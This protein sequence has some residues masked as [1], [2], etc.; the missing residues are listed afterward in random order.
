MAAAQPGDGIETSEHIPVFIDVAGPRGVEGYRPV[1]TTRLA[2]NVANGNFRYEDGAWH[3]T[4]RG[5]KAGFIPLTKPRPRANGT[6]V[7][8]NAKCEALAKSAERHAAERKA[9][10]EYERALAR[11]KKTGSPA[12]KRQSPAE[13][14]EATAALVARGRAASEREGVFPAA[15]DAPPDPPG[16]GDAVQPEDEGLD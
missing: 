16:F 11:S 3:L 4:P 6:P 1:T 7:Y 8:L 9:A 10:D 5:R 12:P 14:E 2:K 13:V 15:P